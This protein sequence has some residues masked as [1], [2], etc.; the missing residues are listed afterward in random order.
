MR[1]FTVVLGSMLIVS[2]VFAASPASAHKPIFPNK[3]TSVKVVEDATVSYALYG[4]SKAA[5]EV[6]IVKG[7]LE[8]GDDLVAELLVPNAKPEATADRDTLPA[9]D[10][11]YPDGRWVEVKDL[12]DREVFDERFTQTSY[13]TISSM[14]TKAPA[15]GQYEWRIR[16]RDSGR[17]VL[18]L[19]KREKFGAADVAALPATISKVKKWAKSNGGNATVRSRKRNQD[20]QYDEVFASAAGA[21]LVIALLASI[22][23]IWRRDNSVADVFWGPMIFT[24]ALAGF[25]ASDQS[26][27]RGWVVLFAVGIWGLRLAAHIGLRW[28]KHDAEDRRYA[29]M[30][31]GWPGQNHVL[32]SL[33]RV[34]LLQACLALVILVPVLLVVAAPATYSVVASAV[35]LG[36]LVVFA[37]GFLLEALADRQLARFMKDRAKQGNGP[38]FCER[39]VW[40]WSRHPN[41]LGEAMLWW[42]I[43]I[44]ALSSPLG[45]LGLIGGLTVTLLVR[46]VSGVPMLEKQWES[47]PGFGDWAQRV[48]V[49]LPIRRRSKS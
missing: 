43:S 25:L 37:V 39:G 42:G 18:V 44:M 3:K 9:I 27:I 36:G 10:V 14:K 40:R 5:G 22:I 24:G 21:V 20:A 31:A 23:G 19:G 35:F 28:K 1:R 33:T 46:Y 8:K 4:Q 26:T 38:A 6:Q 17:Y 41:Y 16:T 12:K 30:R 49:F 45:W 11:K 15:S 48:P 32:R 13:R 2:T 34:Y 47:K 7:P 29:A